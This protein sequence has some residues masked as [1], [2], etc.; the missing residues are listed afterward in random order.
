[1]IGEKPSVTT[2]W[3]KQAIRV[4][5]NS[6]PDKGACN[7]IGRK[8]LAK[9]F[10]AIKQDCHL[11]FTSALDSDEEPKPDTNRLRINRNSNCFLSAVV[12]VAA[13]GRTDL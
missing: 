9:A 1:M 6:P 8:H 4:S 7:F 5:P 10:S 12:E 2:R 11:L 3:V 13:E